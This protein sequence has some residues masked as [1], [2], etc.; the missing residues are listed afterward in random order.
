MAVF[1]SLND[2]GQLSRQKNT[3]VVVGT[4]S[5]DFAH[6]VPAILLTISKEE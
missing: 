3:P 6:E 5:T 2:G 1:A 4:A